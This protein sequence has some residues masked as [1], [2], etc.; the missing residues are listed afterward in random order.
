MADMF[1]AG[2]SGE[3]AAELI[4]MADRYR[5]D[6]LVLAFEEALGAKEFEHGSNRLTETERTI[7]AIEGLEREV[8]NGGYWQFFVNSSNEYAESIVQALERIGCTKTAQITARALDS[9][10]TSELS[11]DAIARAIARDD[12]R[13]DAILEECDTAY[14]RGTDAI[15]DRLFDYI[16]AH[17]SEVRLP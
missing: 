17:Q 9:L 6:S 16:R 2:Y 5:I 4:A 15:A 10:G 3:S 13:R 8:N 7:L 1:L 11:S 12:P 14:F